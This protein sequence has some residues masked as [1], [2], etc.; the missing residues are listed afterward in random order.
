MIIHLII[1]GVT[2]IL[3]L[4]S[5]N[6]MHVQHDK[7]TVDR[8]QMSPN[9]KNGKFQNQ[10]K[11]PTIVTSIWEVS[12]DAIFNR[13]KHSVPEYVP[14]INKLKKEDLES[15]PNDQNHIIWLGHSSVLLK[16]QGKFILTDPVFSFKPSPVSFV[17]TERFH[18]VP[19]EFEELPVIDIVLISHDHYDHLDKPTIEKIKD[20]V[21]QFITPL[22]VGDY[23]KAWGVDEDKIS[24]LDWWQSY[25]YGDF[26]ITSTPA[27]HG[28]GRGLNNRNS[29]LWSGFAVKHSSFNFYYSG[30]TGMM[31][32]FEEIGNRLGPFDLT[33]VQLGAYGDNWPLIHMTPEDAVK[34]H[35]MVEGNKMLPIHWGT[36]NLAFHA[37]DDPINRARTAA[38]KEN[39]DLINTFPGNIVTIQSETELAEE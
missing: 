39:V 12:K 34:S 14:I 3:G 2:L 38:E 7:K 33:L 5:C 18:P 6:T 8:I 32:T 37:W 20:K 10:L 22:A 30:D 28:S 16:I 4:N 1:A 13:S 11:T 35:K 26:S 17:G 27:R 31:P 36:F 19:I 23:L 24:E 15:L 29:T 21:N 9:Y 25:Q